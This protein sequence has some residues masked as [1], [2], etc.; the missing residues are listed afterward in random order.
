MSIQLSTRISNFG[1]WAKCDCPSCQADHFVPFTRYASQAH[2]LFDIFDCIRHARFCNK[3]HPRFVQ[4]GRYIELLEMRLG[5]R[6]MPR[7]CRRVRS[8]PNAR[9]FVASLP[10]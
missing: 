10:H 4:P 5:S 1:V 8:V 2:G 3:P 9:L 6:R 7:R